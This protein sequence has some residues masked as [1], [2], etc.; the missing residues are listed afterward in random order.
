VK[1]LF[2][3]LYVACVVLF[4]T[5]MASFY[6][7]GLGFTSMILFGTTFQ[8]RALPA[9]NAMPKYYVI[10]DGYDGQFY[11]QLAARPAPWDG[12]VK[13]ALDAPGYRAG[14]LLPSLL[15]YAAGLGRPAWAVHVYAAQYL[16]VWLLMALVLLHWFPARSPWDFVCWSGILFSSGTTLSVCRAVPDAFATLLLLVGWYL[17]DRERPWASAVVLGLAG[18]A[19]ETAVLTCAMVAGSVP[20]S[21]RGLRRL[22]ALGL[23]AALPTLLWLVLRL[24][25]VGP[26]TGRRNMGVP[27]V[28][29]YE[30]IVQ[31]GSELAHP[32]GKLW[33]EGSVLVA[34]VVQAAF[35]LFR[36][37]P[38]EVGWRIAMPH[39][40]LML[41]LGVGVWQGYPI[42]AARVLSPLL[43]AFNIALPR[44]PRF[45]PLLL[46][47][48][49]SVCS[50]IQILADSPL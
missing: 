9:V 8:G 20:R 4:L 14:R 39:A 43:V 47:G 24:R 25:L 15:A 27:F 37:R 33:L 28:A 50:G 22:V 36:W 12:E 29:V 2:S 19:R 17:W 18:L 44:K 46:A 26:I 21:A 3:G 49:L 10:G 7:P 23:V 11:A 6:R 1:Y 48:N 45:W 16:V 34:L 32:T 38:S 41:A 13:L 30:R 31:A 5:L 35:F 40:L 42:A